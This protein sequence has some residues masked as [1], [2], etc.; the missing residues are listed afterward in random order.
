MR[1]LEK[2]VRLLFFHETRMA[3]GL[4]HIFHGLETMLDWVNIFLLSI[5]VVG[6]AT[7]DLWY[8]AMGARKS[9]ASRPLRVKRIRLRRE[10]D[11]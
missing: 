3:P 9:G 7:R 4:K 11:A 8:Q 1:L 5:R 2:G 10:V 6:L